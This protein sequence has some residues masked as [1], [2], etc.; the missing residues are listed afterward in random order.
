MRK[1]LYKKGSCVVPE[2]IVVGSIVA[3]LPL[4]LNRTPAPGETLIVRDSGLFAGG[5]G[6]NQAAQ[7]A[8]LGAQVLLVGMVGEDPLGDFLRREIRAELGT[9]AGIGAS[10]H[11]MTSYAVPV[12]DPAG[13]YIL[14]VP[15]ANQRLTQADVTRSASLWGTANVLLVQGETTPEG[16]G[17][18]MAEMRRRGGTIILDPAPVAGMTPSLLE[19]TTVLTPNAVEFAQLL[20]AEAVIDE[21]EL[22]DAA[23]ALLGRLPH[24]RTLV[25][26]LG[27]QGVLLAQRGM[28]PMRVQAPQI[29]E[30]DP[31]A[32]GDAFNGALAWG[33]LQG[34]PMVQAVQ[35]GV[36]AGALT[37]SRRGALPALPR[38]DELI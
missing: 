17:S 30:V 2:I 28:D 27:A 1:S 10:P 7:A 22:G 6:L 19:Q 33:L 32:A 38:C 20:H 5:K 3:D 13:Q 11:A 23:A 21:L 25:V 35:L 18:A 37:A 31:T 15:G 36:R 12:I 14:H 34:W 8:R 26:T 4:W 16:T 9:D 29:A 24:L